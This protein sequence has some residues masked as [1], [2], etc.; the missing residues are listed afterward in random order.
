MTH[1][2]TSSELF[3]ELNYKLHRVRLE[4]F[5]WW[6]GFARVPRRSS[7]SR[8]AFKMKQKF[9]IYYQR[10]AIVTI[11]QGS[12]FCPVALVFQDSQVVH[13]DRLALARQG[14]HPF[15]EVLWAKKIFKK[16]VLIV[17]RKPN[18]FIMRLV[19]NLMLCLNA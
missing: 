11:Y 10:G 9:K 16:E 19:C 2:Y 12:H 17:F 7:W 4:I 3:Q 5:T 13:Q 6:S 1:C 15:L 18:R 8:A 14:S